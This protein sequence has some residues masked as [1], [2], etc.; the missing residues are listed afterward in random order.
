MGSFSERIILPSGNLFY[1][2]D[3]ITI[4]P[5]EITD[6][7]RLARA[8]KRKDIV[9]INDVLDCV[10]DVDLRDLWMGD[11]RYIM[12]WLRINSL[13]KIPYTLNWTS[14][15]GNRNTT[16]VTQTD[17]Q[18]SML[19]DSL[20]PEQWQHYQ[21]LGLTYPNVRDSEEWITTQVKLSED[22]RWIYERAQYVDGIDIFDKIRRLSDPRRHCLNALSDIKEFSELLGKGGVKEFVKV[23]DRHFN[24][25]AAFDRLMLELKDIETLLETDLEMTAEQEDVMTTRLE[26]LR[27]ET[28]RLSTGEAEPM[29]ETI[30]MRISVFAFFP[31]I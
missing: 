14:F 18:F 13:T 1:N 21:A 10:V 5:F 2:F 27:Q 3:S 9:M 26:L 29:L 23:Q 19:T 30:P 7:A 24:A 12:Y 20:S 25:D 15:Y 4:R 22:D 28:E 11:Y 31:G 16:Q 17:L 6:L 8:I